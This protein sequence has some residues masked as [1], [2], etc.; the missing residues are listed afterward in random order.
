MRIAV[1]ILLAVAVSLMGVGKAWAAK[2]KKAHDHGNPLFSAV[3]KLNLTDEQKAKVADLK[4]EYGPKLKE[5]H[6]Q[7]DSILTPEQKKDRDEALK[8]AKA[9]KKRLSPKELGEV[10]KLTDEQKAKMAEAGK[11][12]H[13]LYK[14][15]RDKVMEILTPEQKDQ[16]KAM[17]PKHEKKK[18]AQ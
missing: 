3:E 13:A 8:A 10:M 1:S 18:D 14:E 16:L 9:E 7:M 11:A 4:K 6:D 2:E 5:A 17:A 15:V 12:N